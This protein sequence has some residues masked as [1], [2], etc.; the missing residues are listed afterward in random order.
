MNQ[1][2]ILF[3]FFLC[4]LMAGCNTNDPG[5]T[6]AVDPEAI[7]FDYKIMGDENN[8]DLTILIQFR[9]DEPEGPTILLKDPARVE[10]DGEV[11]KPDSSRLTGAYYEIQKP[12]SGFEGKHLIKFIDGNGKEY[13]EEFY[14]QPLSLVSA[15]PESI[16]RED[17]VIEL[18]GLEK[19]DHVRILLTDTSVWS[20]GINRVDT[21]QNG[22]VLI[23][24]NDLGAVVNGPVHLELIRESE[25]PIKQKTQ[26]GGMITVSYG[27]SREL[28]LKD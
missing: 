13:T 27:L 11:I 16:K 14:F 22:R 17:L 12:V 19:E 9:F 3:I 20:E 26:R 5:D 23:S 6:S 2:G 1:P 18:Q 15:L 4:L 7:Y 28:N 10:L 24:K 8:E 25:R 21:V